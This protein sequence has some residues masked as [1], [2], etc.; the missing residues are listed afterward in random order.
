MNDVFYIGVLISF[1]VVLGLALPYIESE[2]GVSYSVLTLGNSLSNSTDSIDDIT[3]N[4]LTTLE[5]DVNIFDFLKGMLKSFIFT[6]GILPIWLETILYIP[7]IILAVLIYR[8]IRS[9]AG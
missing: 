6:A 3:D 4:S 2:F 1:F 9:G 8:L 7:R 5:T